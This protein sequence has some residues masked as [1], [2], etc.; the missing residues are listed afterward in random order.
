MMFEDTDARAII[1]VPPGL[2]LQGNGIA[3]SHVQNVIFWFFHVD[4]NVCFKLETK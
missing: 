2:E 3:K 4:I 1:T